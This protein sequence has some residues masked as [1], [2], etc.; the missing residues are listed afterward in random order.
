M[1]GSTDTLT[2]VD[3]VQRPRSR[4][5]TSERVAALAQRHGALGVLLLACLVSAVLF[6]SFGS[7]D[8]L[9]GIAIQSATLIIVALGMTF[10]IISG[11]IDL[12]VGSVFAL[13]GVLAAWAA[14]WGP[15]AAVGLPLLVCGAIG[16]INGL[17]IAR[18]GLEP[19][20]VTLA[21]LLGARG[22][23]LAVTD[24]GAKTYLVPRDSGLLD[25][26]AARPSASGTR[27]SSHCCSACSAR[28]CCN[29]VATGRPSSRSAA[30]P[31]RRH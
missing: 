1:T 30:T 9:V 14:Q 27:S 25:V 4:A 23:L 2:T 8:N 17:V 31:R 11:G 10:V 18:S 24:E 28:S 20:I 22:L 15:L 6:P 5:A 29:A 12:S 16:L 19:F 7:R 26:G 13:G 3:A 21:S